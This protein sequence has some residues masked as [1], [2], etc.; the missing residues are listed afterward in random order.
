M[1]VTIYEQSFPGIESKTYRMVLFSS[2]E[3]GTV[4]NHLLISNDLEIVSRI[5]NLPREKTKNVRNMCITDTQYQELLTI[6][7]VRI[8]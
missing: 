5:L 8:R 1:S 4:S 2:D 3:R 6:G 7:S